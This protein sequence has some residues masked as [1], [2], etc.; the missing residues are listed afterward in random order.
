V[1]AYMLRVS[2]TAGGSL[3]GIRALLAVEGWVETHPEVVT[4]DPRVA[5]QVTESLAV[6]HQVCD[7]DVVKGARG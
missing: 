3:E 1:A 4:P 7:Q 6:A 5:A 2:G